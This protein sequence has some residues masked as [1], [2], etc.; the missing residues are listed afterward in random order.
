MKTKTATPVEMRKVM[1]A[2]YDFKKAG[3]AFV[4]VPIIP[5]IDGE[6]GERLWANF[7]RRVMVLVTS[8]CRGSAQEDQDNERKEQMVE[9]VDDGHV[10]PPLKT[11]R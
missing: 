6:N 8:D 1:K 5:E 2:V 11:H 3:I 4:P 7:N 10:P 9:H